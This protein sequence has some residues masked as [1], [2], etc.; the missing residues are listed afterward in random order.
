MHIHGHIQSTQTDNNNTFLSPT[1][2]SF[3]LLFLL[4]QPLTNNVASQGSLLTCDNKFSA[5]KRRSY[6]RRTP[7]EV[8]I[9]IKAAQHIENLL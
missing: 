5:H 7:E 3:L 6:V 8:T 1:I 9:P 4:K 2:D